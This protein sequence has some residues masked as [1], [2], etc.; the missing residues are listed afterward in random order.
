MKALLDEN[1][2]FHFSEHDGDAA[3]E[4]VVDTGAIVR[5]VQQMKH[6]R[7]VSSKKKFGS[8]VANYVGSVNIDLLRV[9]CR[10]KNIDF[11]EAMRDNK[12]LI[13][14]LNDPDNA[15]FKAVDGKI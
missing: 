10:E 7:E 15:K 11:N 2:I 5:H 3:I 4:T 14:Y 9:W 1:Q 8:E 6:L 12:I 13:Q